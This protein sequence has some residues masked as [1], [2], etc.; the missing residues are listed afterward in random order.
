MSGASDERDLEKRW[1]DEIEE[2]LRKAGYVATTGTLHSHAMRIVK[3]GYGP[4][5]IAHRIRTD[6]I[7]NQLGGV[8]NST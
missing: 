7:T 8:K 4:M 1:A 3:E 2:M 5:E 6:Q